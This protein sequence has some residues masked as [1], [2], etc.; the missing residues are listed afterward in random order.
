MM[1]LLGLDCELV[2][3]QY[4]SGALVFLCTVAAYAALILLGSRWRKQFE[5]AGLRY[6]TTKKEE[7]VSDLVEAVWRPRLVAALYGLAYF[8]NGFARIAFSIW[9]PFFLFQVRGLGTLEVALFVGL[10]YVSWG[11]K[12]S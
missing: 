12:M 7:R 9:L 3:L 8:T 10:I 11:W 6:W 1:V 4:V 2:E 5:S